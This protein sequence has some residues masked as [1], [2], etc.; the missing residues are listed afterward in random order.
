M[1]IFHTFNGDGAIYLPAPI[2]Q[3][4]I[5]QYARDNRRSIERYKARWREKHGRNFRT[6]WS[7]YFLIGLTSIA[8]LWG[9]VQPSFS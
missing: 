2:Y 8:Q 1:T 3:R 5:E 6:L 7:V 4:D 9:T